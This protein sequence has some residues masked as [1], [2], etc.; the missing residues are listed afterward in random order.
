MHSMAILCFYPTHFAAHLPGQV[1]LHKEP[2]KNH[3]TKPAVLSFLQVEHRHTGCPAVIGSVLQLQAP[4][5]VRLAW[6]LQQSGASL[7]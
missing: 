7:V 1:T 3:T 5:A 2:L 4:A 6:S